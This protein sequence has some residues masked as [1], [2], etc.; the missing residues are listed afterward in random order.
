[1]EAQLIFNKFQDYK[2]VRIQINVIEKEENNAKN[3][4][5]MFSHVHMHLW[6]KKWYWGCFLHSKESTLVYCLEQIL[7]FRMQ[8]V[9][10]IRLLPIFDVVS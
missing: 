4:N 3:N 7:Q 1:M 2:G 6:S 10:Q 9:F 5:Q 8:I